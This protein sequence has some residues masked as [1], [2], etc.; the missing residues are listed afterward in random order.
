M[1]TMRTLL[2]TTAILLAGCSAGLAQVSTMGTTAMALSTTPGTV[3][4]S[5][6]NGPSP[7]SPTTQGSVPDTTLTPVPLALNP[8]E[9]GTVVTCSTP[10]GQI[11]PGTPAVTLPSMSLLGNTAGSMPGTVS[12]TMA[13]LMPSMSTMPGTVSTSMAG[14]MPLTSAMPSTSTSTTSTTTTTTLANTLTTMTIPVPVVISTTGAIAPA[15]PLGGALTTVCSDI[16]GGPPSTAADLPLRTPEIP[17]NPSLGTIQPTVPQLVDTSIDP[18]TGSNS[19]M[20]SDP[21][22]SVMPTPNTSACAESVTMNLST[23][24][25]MAPANATG[26]AATPGVSPA[27]C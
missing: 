27:G 2:L 23:P 17:M 26:A 25:T 19:S 7:F 22:M 4:T 9:P 15:S 10:I 14:S 13:G 24:G 16:S 3:L 5:P 11:V 20:S 1:A 6:I 12:T 8:T 21:S 18:S